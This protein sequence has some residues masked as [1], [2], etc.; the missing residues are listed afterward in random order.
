MARP[1]REELFFCDFPK[2][3]L[4]FFSDRTTRLQGSLRLLGAVCPGV[5]GGVDVGGARVVWPRSPG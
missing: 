2:A 1:L 5:N 4:S 3:L